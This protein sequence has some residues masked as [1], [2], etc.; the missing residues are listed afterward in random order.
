MPEV[1]N[2]G[3]L[4]E[5]AD[6]KAEVARAKLHRPSDWYCDNT[7]CDG[8]PHG[9]WHQN[10]ARWSQ[11]PPEGDWFVWLLMTG[12][13]F[14]KT[15]SGAE[16]LV[17]KARRNHGEYAAVAPTWR[18]VRL[19]V[20]QGPSGLLNCLWDDEL[21][22]YNKGVGDITLRNGSIVH[23][24]SADQPDRLRGYNL[25]G[26][27]G[28]EFAA[29]RY[30]AAYDEGLIPSL[31]IGNPQLVLTTTPK[32]TKLVLRVVKRARDPEDVAFRLTTGSM[33]DNAA[34]LSE[35]AI[36]EIDHMYKGTRLGRQEI[37]GELI[38][39]VEGSVT[40]LEVI[41][42]TRI[43]NLDDVP[44]LVRIVVAIDPAVTS[45]EGSDATGIVVMGK[46]VDGHGY[47]LADYTVRGATPKQWARKSA[48]AYRLWEADR[49][50]GEVNNGG[51]LIAFT[52]HTVDPRLP[53][54]SVRAS[55]GKRVRAEPV[56]ALYDLNRIHHVGEFPDLETQLC[57]WTTEDPDS[58]DNLDALVWAAYALGLTASGDWAS[59]FAPP[60]VQVAGV[61]AQKQLPAPRPGSWANVY[62][63][64][65]RTKRSLTRGEPDEQDSSGTTP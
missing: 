48:A 33:R 52:I 47:V 21:S 31:R 1:Q 18:D 20:A 49:I 29:W 23:L 5:L 50:V 27:W 16:W 9:R 13:G 15:R 57:T 35:A 64:Q 4:L 36:A 19:I 51:D 3:K 30:P 58:P 38:E 43:W 60:K 8:R 24:A 39:E 17:E 62:L 63:G 28:D 44:D 61:E 25:S 54:Q 40:T 42:R 7:D 37:Q 2:A 32:L 14:G 11:H 56:S 10:H 53:F 12:R 26:A 55:R 6:L 65:E 45:G 46:G 41:E 22:D 34:N 59:L